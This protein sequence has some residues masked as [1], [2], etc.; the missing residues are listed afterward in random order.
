ML[1]MLSMPVT[2]ELPFILHLWLGDAVPDY[3]VQF[4]VLTLIIMILS[5]LNTPLSQVVHASGK[6]K[7]YQV[8]TS[9]VVCS[10]LPV[11]WVVLKMDGNPITV[12]IVC[13]TMTVVN[14]AVCLLLLKRIFPYSIRE[15]LK[16]VIWPCAIVTIVAT[17]FPVI[18][19]ILM[20]TS[21]VRMLLVAFVGVMSTAVSS[22]FL[23]LDQSEK[24]MIIEFIQKRFNKKKN[25]TV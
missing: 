17:I 25:G 15:Y 1:F 24:S 18:I 21:L 13:L 2:L 10:I 19:V 12:Y 8:G 22:Y 6:M 4:T 9:I 16:N 23:V 7:A 20:K 14:Q 5:S 11:A 3:T